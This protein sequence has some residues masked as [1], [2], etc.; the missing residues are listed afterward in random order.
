MEFND[1]LY[2]FDEVSICRIINTSLLSIRKSWSESMVYS[3]WS[4]PKRAGG[5]VNYLGTFCENPQFV[6]N[7]KNNEPD[8]TEE[9]LINLDQLSRRSVGKDNLTIGLFIMRVED[10]RK[11]RLHGVKPKVVSSTFVNSRSVF[12]RH[13][14]AN[15]RY[16]CI[17]S[18]YEPQLIGRFLLRI[19]SDENNEL[20]FVDNLIRLCELMKLEII[21]FLNLVS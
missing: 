1:F 9:V 6:F 7:I 16:V 15:G 2:Y 21:C 14:F 19:Y 12:L 11:Y 8:K 17:P 4:T 18:T 13:K 10:N 20:A 3:E 5:C